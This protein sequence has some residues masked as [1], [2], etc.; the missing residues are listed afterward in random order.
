[1]VNLTCVSHLSRYWRGPVMHHWEPKLCQQ[2]ALKHVNVKPKPPTLTDL[3]QSGTES[4]G[5]TSR[6]PAG[7]ESVLVVLLSALQENPPFCLI[8]VPHVLQMSTRVRWRALESPL[9]FCFVWPTVSRVYYTDVRARPL[10]LSLFICPSRLIAVI[11]QWAVVRSH[12]SG[13][14]FST[15]ATHAEWE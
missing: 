12:K 3:T 15:S 13:T 8:F 14:L 5:E 4:R 1:M 2:K 7:A 10:S 9:L 6:G 11:K